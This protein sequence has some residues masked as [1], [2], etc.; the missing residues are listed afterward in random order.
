[1]RPAGTTQAPV[2]DPNPNGH[3]LFE[4][5][6]YAFRVEDVGDR[7]IWRFVFNADTSPFEYSP[8]L[9]SNYGVPTAQ[10]EHHNTC[11][12]LYTSMTNLSYS[13]QPSY[14]VPGYTDLLCNRDDAPDWYFHKNSNSSWDATQNSSTCP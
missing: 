3:G 2:Y 14:W 7:G 1:M 12:S 10:S 9:P 4:D 13:S 6:S 8:T 5:T 11:D